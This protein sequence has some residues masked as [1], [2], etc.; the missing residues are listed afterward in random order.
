M[1][2]GVNEI[3][4]ML[5][6]QKSDGTCFHGDASILLVQAIVEQT[7]LTCLFAMYDA[8]GGDKAVSKCGFSMVNVCNDRDVSDFAR[9]MDDT[10]DV[11]VTSVLANHRKYF[12]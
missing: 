11:F 7:Q 10:F 2:W 8:I 1:S 3:D 12:Y 4:K 6:M 5:L 9:L